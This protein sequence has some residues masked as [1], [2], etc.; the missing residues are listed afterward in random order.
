M[1]ITVSGMFVFVDIVG[2][3]EVGMKF[4]KI[5]R[6]MGLKLLLY[7]LHLGPN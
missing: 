3:C 7:E 4:I 2:E 6:D 5:Q 1:G